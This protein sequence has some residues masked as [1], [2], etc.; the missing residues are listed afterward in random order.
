MR[1]PPGRSAAR[2]LRMSVDSP[3]TPAAAARR[4]AFRNGVAVAARGGTGLEWLADLSPA[5][6][7]AAAA[8][9]MPDAQASTAP[10]ASGWSRR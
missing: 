10:R 5:E 1:N 8:R 2:A 7:R 6:Q 3:R 9:L 4:L